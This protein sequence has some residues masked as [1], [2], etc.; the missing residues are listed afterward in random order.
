MLF[1]Q[2]YYKTICLIFFTFVFLLINY[3]YDFKK[4][5]LL[6]PFPP[7]QSIPPLDQSLLFHINGSIKSIGKASP[8]YII[9][10]PSRPDRRT[11]SIAL[12]QTLNLEAFIV[13][14]YSIHSTE[15]LS[16]NKYRNKLLLKLTELACWASHMRVWLTIANNTPCQNNAWSIIVEDDIDLE[17]DTP[18]IMQSFSQ[19]MWNEADLI[20][21]GHCANT[22]GKLIDQSSKHNYRVHQALH[23]SCTHAYAIRS[24]AARKLIYLLSKPSR[25]I[26]DSIVKLV[27]NHQLVAYSIHP[28]LAMQQPV[29]KNNPSDVNQIDRQSF[30][31]R[32]Q[33]SIYKFTQW[34][35]SVPSYEKLN[36]SALQKA[37]LTKAISWRK[38][39]E[40]GIWKNI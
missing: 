19:A 15:I 25:A 32:I 21:L 3:S 28:P 36:K 13:P 34:L 12:M 23:P 10:L 5:Y 8:I 38:M 2:Q 17:I 1:V 35:Y 33:F 6:H 16:R 4:Y 22:P 14:A 7:I 26:D 30:I 29:S 24:D 20:Y 40:K 39:Y 9:N 18:Q 31:Y 11:E 37:N 27:D